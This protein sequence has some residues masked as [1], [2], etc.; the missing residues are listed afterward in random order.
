MT[1][2]V[3][4]DTYEPSLANLIVERITSEHEDAEHMI[5]QV[6]G[7][8]SLRVYPLLP[9]PLTSDHVQFLTRAGSHYAFE[10]DDIDHA[11]TYFERALSMFEHTP[12][13]LELVLQAA[14]VKGVLL[15][16]D[17]Q[18]EASR[19][20]FSAAYNQVITLFHTPRYV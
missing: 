7:E 3:V 1:T 4:S 14:F 16:R 5:A 9:S 15:E 18:V 11:Q 2:A 8:A 19:A 20:V 10:L 6:F 12:P 13:P 17:G